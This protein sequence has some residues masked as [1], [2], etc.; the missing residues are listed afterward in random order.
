[1]KTS[2]II[3]TIAFATFTAWLMVQSIPNAPIN[4]QTASIYVLDAHGDVI[5]CDDDTTAKECQK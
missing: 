4:T 5:D 1:M 3:I 2:H